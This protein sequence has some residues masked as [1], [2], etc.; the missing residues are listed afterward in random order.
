M[1]AMR[2]VLAAFLLILIALPGLAEFTAAEAALRRGEHAM[3]YEHCKA[4]AEKGD[5][6]CQNLLG[7][8]FQKGLGV[9][10]DLKEAIRLFT[11]AAGKK[12]A[13]AQVNLGLLYLNGTGVARDEAEAARWLGLAADQGDPIGEY[14]LALLLLAG[15]GVERDTKR[16]GELL[17]HGADRGYVPA[18]LSLALAYETA[19]PSRI[20]L[21]YFWYR[22]AGVRSRDQRLK[23]LANDGENRT[24]MYLSGAEIAAARHTADVWKPVGPGLEF[25]ILGARPPAAAENAGGS[26][27]AA[28][29]PSSGT[30][31]IVGHAGDV[32]TN[33]HVVEGCREMK[34]ERAGSKIAAQVVATDPGSDLA[35]LRLPDPAEDIASFRK[36]DPPKPGEAVL[37]IGYPLHGLL[38]SGASVTTGIVSAVAGVRNDP[39]QLQITAP[40]QPGNSGG[41]LVGAGGTVIG[42]VVSKINAIKIAQ[43]TGAIPENINFAVN[44]ALAR[45][46]LD[47]NGVRYEE[48][49]PAGAPLSTPLIAERAA[50]YTVMIECYR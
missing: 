41:P 38:S 19:R 46:L 23:T 1:Q 24:I 42:I 18:Q 40:V 36:A 47:K 10:E 16:A 8:L 26:L 7:V 14:R 25:G 6:E 29:P 11:A 32:V 3:A 28:K 39:K 9:T 5:P 4:E 35:V 21:A 13:A 45:A 30:G 12:L 17:R 44:T 48:A 2:L 20:G 27:S 43:A 15:K 31:F 37:V 34:I 49:N 50:K 22:I 33:N